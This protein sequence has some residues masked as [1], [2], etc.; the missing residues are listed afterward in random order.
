MKITGKIK[1]IFP[2]KQ[3]K[4]TFKKREF[5]LDYETNSDYPQ[6]IKLELVNDLCSIIDD[7]KKGDMVEVEFELKGREWKN[8]QGEIIYFTT[9]RALKLK[10]L[11]E[12]S[13]T[14]SPENLSD[15]P[16][17]INGENSLPS[18]PEE[19]NDLPF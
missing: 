16:N 10:K 8:Q 11:E 12:D 19:N 18:P 17:S 13:T 6:V 9:L 15:T 7:Y 2:E 3:I 4:E 5:V 1:E 14:M